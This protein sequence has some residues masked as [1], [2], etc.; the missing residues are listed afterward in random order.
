MKRILIPAL[1]SLLASGAAVAQGAPASA[2]KVPPSQRLHT[3]KGMAHD[4]VA[5]T[6]AAPGSKFDHYPTP[7]QSPPG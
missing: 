4:Q 1:M 5:P 7:K 2:P 3:S 6:P